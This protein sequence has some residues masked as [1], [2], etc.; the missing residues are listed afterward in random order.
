MHS[1]SPWAETN[2]SR[3]VDYEGIEDFLA[4]AGIDAE[5]ID[6][7]V[8]NIWCCKNSQNIWEN[9]LHLYFYDIRVN[10]RNFE[11][12]RKHNPLKKYVYDESNGGFYR[13]RRPGEWDPRGNDDDSDEE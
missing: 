4:A 6:R 10:D 7:F 1:C 12:Y 9:P 3:T 5:M 8:D 2:H 13:E 11:T